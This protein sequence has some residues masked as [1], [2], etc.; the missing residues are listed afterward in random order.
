MTT[1]T[2][3]LALWL[4]ILVA[5]TGA[6]LAG[7][8]AVQQNYRISANDP[9]IQIAEDTAALLNNGA[10]P[11]SAVPGARIDLRAS[12][13]SWVAIYT[14]SGTPLVSTGV[15]ENAPPQF[16]A[17]VFK[18][19]TWHK[20]A[21]LGISF[22]LDSGQNRFSWQPAPDLRQAVVIVQAKNGDF[23]ASGRNMR[24]VEAREAVL[25][26]GIALAWALTELGTLICIALL[27]SF[28]WL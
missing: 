18:T 26:E 7:Y 25:T 12:L 14:A 20:Y 21:E 17:G 11:T 10:A 23:V 6:F 19:S 3:A 1:F 5:T 15:L 16:P 2:R 8:W 9:Q 4:P 13:A 28:G 22:P 27:L 24:E